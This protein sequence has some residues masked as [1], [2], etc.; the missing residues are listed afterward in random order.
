MKQ[1]RLWGTEVT[2]VDDKDFQ[3]GLASST[4][5][6]TAHEAEQLA[7]KLNEAARQVR[8]A[9]RPKDKWIP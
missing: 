4:P 6:M 2:V 5:D 1:V 8:A 3:Y 7:K 9:N